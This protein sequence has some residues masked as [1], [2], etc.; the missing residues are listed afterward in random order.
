[1]RKAT[2]ILTFSVISLVLSGC[3]PGQLL[4]PTLTPTPTP[5]P[6]GRLI[7]NISYGVP[8]KNRKLVL[9]QIVEE[10]ELPHL[11]DCTLTELVTTSNSDGEFS[12]DDVPP[13]DYFILYDHVGFNSG[14]ERW[15]GKT[16]KLGDVEWTMEEFYIKSDLVEEG[17]IVRSQSPLNCEGFDKLNWQGQGFYW[18]STLSYDSSPFIVAHDVEAACVDIIMALH[19]SITV[20]EIVSGQTSEVELQVMYFGPDYSPEE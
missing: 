19:N 3:G 2:M 11:A 13:G 5:V 12:F 15:K 10:L 20:V 18:L 4:G 16:L 8:I 1:M 14:L 6:G 9:C 17:G 7:G